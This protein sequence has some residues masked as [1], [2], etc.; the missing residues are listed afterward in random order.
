M[1]PPF[2]LL[3]S[4]VASAACLQP[5]L[6]A[7]ERGCCLAVAEK[8]RKRTAVTVHH[9]ALDKQDGGKLSWLQPPPLNPL[10][11]QISVLGSTRGGLAPWPAVSTQVTLSFLCQ[12][13]ARWGMA[14]AR[15]GSQ[16]SCRQAERSSKVLVSEPPSALTQFPEQD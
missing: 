10:G 6:K 16:G 15:T 4:A 8:G 11:Q 1:I 7:T 2:L 13:W 3:P 9:G 5:F 14:P 12:Q